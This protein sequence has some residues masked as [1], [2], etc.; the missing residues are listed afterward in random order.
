MKILLLHRKTFSGNDVY[1]NNLYK[2]LKEHT[3]HQIQLH[4]ISKQSEYFPFLTHKFLP[5]EAA[6]ANLIITQ[7]ELAARLSKVK[8][9]KIAVAYH[10]PADPALLQH[11]PYLKRNYYRWWLARAYWEGINSADHIVAISY[12]TAKAIK[13]KHTNKAT[14]TVCYPGVDIAKFHC[15]STSWEQSQSPGYRILFVGNTSIRKGFDLLFPVMRILGNGYTLRF[16]SGLRGN[17][18]PRLIPPN[19]VPLGR[20]SEAELLH[21]LRACDVLLFPSRLEG[22]GYTA[23][24]A[25]ACGK[26]VVAVHVS[27]LPEIIPLPG[28][29]FLVAEHD[30]AQLADAVRNACHKPLEPRV[31]SAWVAQ[32]FSLLEQANGF[33]RVI[34]K[35]MQA[36]HKTKA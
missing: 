27:T 11:L 16:T 1:F 15:N 21:E 35:L 18:L 24:E 29:Q 28:Q 13:L 20:L 12:A 23:V 10:N 5:C 25:M 32:R 26:A 6:Q 3:E 30:P 4:A 31:L 9:P 34:A 22:F 14:V 8:I 2:S 36:E 19:A 7:A 33:L 17:D